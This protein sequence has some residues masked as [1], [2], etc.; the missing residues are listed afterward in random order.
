MFRGNYVFLWTMEFF[1]CLSVIWLDN[2]K[3]APSKSLEDSPDLLV[4][5]D[6]GDEAQVKKLSNRFMIDYV[7]KC[8]EVLELFDRFYSRLEELIREYESCE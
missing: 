6:E 2:C 5:E 7:S 4:I 3:E 1:M 8:R